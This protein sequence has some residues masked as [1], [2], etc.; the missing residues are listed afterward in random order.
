MDVYFPVENSFYF[1][2]NCINNIY[3]INNSDITQLVIYEDIP[4]QFDISNLNLLNPF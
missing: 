4:Y 1:E 2:I 3:Y